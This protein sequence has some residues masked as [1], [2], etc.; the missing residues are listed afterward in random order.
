MSMFVA[1]AGGAGAA[2]CFGSSAVMQRAIARQGADSVHTAG[3]VMLAQLPVGL[4]LLALAP[5]HGLDAPTAALGWAGIGAA[6]GFA[7]TVV[8]LLALARGMVAMVAPFA[9][10][11]GLLVACSGLLTGTGASTGTLIGLVVAA[12]G[13]VIA[14]GPGLRGSRIAM[15]LGMLAAC[16]FASADLA[17]LAA[18]SSAGTLAGAGIVVCMAALAGLPLV[19]ARRSRSIG[20][21]ALPVAC[22]LTLGAGLAVLL[23]GLGADVAVAGLVSAQHALVAVIGGTLVLAE[24]LTRPQ[25]LSIALVLAGI[26]IVAI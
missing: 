13:A 21:P 15:A 7:A 4:I 18:A 17:G 19:I 26:A 2:L 16:L 20:Q 14:L 24:R 25:K 1:I 11:S 12:A 8:M 3:L 10:M 23:A 6:C 5:G 9:G 22:G